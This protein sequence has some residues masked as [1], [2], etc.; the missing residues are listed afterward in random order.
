G[1]ADS[2]HRARAW[3]TAF[4]SSTWL[5]EITGRADEPPWM[6]V[7]G[8]S[9]SRSRAI[10]AV[11]ADTIDVSN[12]ATFSVFRRTSGWSASCVLALYRAGYNTRS[13]SSTAG[14]APR[15]YSGP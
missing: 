1:N 8:R 10:V 12:G 7:M 6:S 4:S 5:I 15:L 2:I 9:A 13:A 3:A 11:I 14:S